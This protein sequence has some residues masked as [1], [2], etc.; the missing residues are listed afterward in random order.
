[1]PGSNSRP[2]N[3]WTGYQIGKDGSDKMI[4]P[5]KNWTSNLMVQRLFGQNGSR[6]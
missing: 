5:I 4:R 2:F 1:M 6:N 3:F